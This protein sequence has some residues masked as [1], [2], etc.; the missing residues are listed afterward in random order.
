MPAEVTVGPLVLS[1]NR[2]TTFMVTDERGEVDARSEQGIFADDTRF[3]SHLR[4]TIQGKPW[5][6][7]TSA[8]VHHYTVQLQLANP[9]LVTSA[10][11]LR[12]HDLGLTV[13][14]MVADGIHE[15]LDITSYALQTVA[16]KFE[17]SI[18][19]DFAD[20]FEVRAHHIPARSG[21]TTAWD[22]ERSELSIEYRNQDFERRVV[23]RLT[24]SGSP[25]SF[26]HSR[27]TLAFDVTLQ[28]GEAWHCC[29][30]YALSDDERSREP[31]T[32]SGSDR[33]ALALG[34]LQAEWLSNATLLT[35]AN[36]D[37][38]RAY[39][40]SVKDIGALR[41]HHQDLSPDAWVAAAG[42]PWYVALFGRDSLIASLQTMLV[43]PAFALGALKKLAQYQA[44]A[45]DDW[46][47][48]EPGKILHELRV[49]ELAHFNRIPHTPYYGTA[50]ATALY[51]IVL[52]EAWKW[53]GDLR[54]LR[55]HRDVA[56]RCLEW[57]DRYGDL[58]GDG[59]QE[60][61][62]RSPHG[63]E[64]MGWKDSSDAIV[65]PDGRPVPQPKA[66]VELQGYVFDAKLRMAE[67]FDVL[68]EPD[69]AATLR[70][71]AAVL[72]QRFEDAF[73]SDDLGAYVLCLDPHKE[74]V[75]TLASNVGHC[76]WSGIVRPD[77]AERMLP[78][79]FGDEMWTGWG[80]R[81]LAA[82][83]PAFNPFSYHNGSIWPHDNGLLALGLKRYGFAT[84]AARVARDIFGAASYFNRYRLPELYAGLS[85]RE[86]AFPVQ[87]IGAN[88][89][90]AWAAG[91]IFDLL[92]A[93]LGLR[94]DAS[95]RL[96]YVDPT[97]PRWLPDVTLGGLAVGESRLT[98][99]FWREGE[100]SRWAVVDQWRGPQVTVAE[101]PWTPWRLGDANVKPV[102]ATP[103]T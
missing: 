88:V 8:V 59:F 55:E 68:G 84:E 3:V 36:E 16:F 49:G 2:G 23:Y 52:H 69:R 13:S 83:N 94:A 22:S 1:I 61:Q 78:R 73:W 14:R 28:P 53:L 58:D 57:I 4:L 48:A 39:L 31:P 89:P 29:A 47:D 76:L 63:Y 19:S 93:I 67:V 77:R 60:Y 62:T 12:A 42:V 20:I 45:V 91:S 95:R 32:C 15:D 101:E 24:N 6:L 40:R 92:R 41:M 11:D 80:V 70:S 30:G 86:T 7:L 56:L 99:R 100:R 38:Y 98:I 43:Q 17:V 34:R 33:S 102:V 81:T 97:L 64:N 44:Q 103:S 26:S 87:Y 75:K 10:G 21:I 82:G 74:P 18:D 96:L 71:Q 46:R 65:Y 66:L 25:A 72:Q 37:V 51:L 85:K 90:Q 27:N 9:A 50:D 5:V 54:L 35:S 79:I